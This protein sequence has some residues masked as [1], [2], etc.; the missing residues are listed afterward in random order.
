MPEPE[1]FKTWNTTI[2]NYC[3]SSKHQE[4]FSLFISLRRT[5]SPSRDYEFRPDH[6]TF[7]AL[8]KSCAAI[9]AI[10]L[11]RSF[12][13]FGVKIGHYNELNQVL[14][15]GLMN[16]YAKCG[17]LNDAQK[18]FDDMSQ[19]D[20]PV[21]WNILLSGYAGLRTRDHY[22]DL[23]NL[24]YEMHI[25]KEETKPNEITVAIVLPVCA[26]VRDLRSGKSIHAYVIKSGLVSQTLVGNSLVSMY[27]KCGFAHNDGFLVFSLISCKDVVSWNSMISG[28]IENGFLSDSFKL[29]RQMLKGLTMPNYATIA[30]I[31]PVCAFVEHDRSYFYG[32]EIHCY[33]LRRFELAEEVSVCNSLVSFYSRIG[34]LEEA[35]MVFRRMKSRDLVSWNAIIAGYASNGGGLQKALDLFH[36]LVLTK[37]VKPDSVTLISV[38]PACAQL[39]N[40]KEGQKIHEYVLRDP[41]LRKDTAI[42]NAL[43]SFYSKFNEI[44]AAFRTFMMIPTKDLISWNSVLDAYAE[45]GF[46]IQ[47]VGLL[48]QMF[49]E[50]VRP[51]SITILTVLRVCVAASSAEKIK[52]VHGFS[53]RSGLLLNDLEPTVGNALLDAY[54]KC[55]NM[56]YAIKTFESLLGK[57]NLI[58]NNA[59]ISGY[60]NHGSGENAEMIFNKISQKDLTTWNLMV[61]FHAENNYPDQAINLFHELQR[62]VKPDMLSI[63]SFLPVCACLASLRFVKQCHGYVIRSCFEDVRLNGALL[64][65]Y[66]KCGNIMSAYK[67]FEMSPQKDLVLFTAM[68][69]GFAMHGM[70]DEALQVFYEMLNSGIKPDHII[71]TAALSACS[72]AGLIDQGWKIFESIKRIHGIEPTMENYACLVDLL[73]RGGRLRDAYNFVIGMP[74]EANANI[75]GTLLGACRKQ[76]DLELGRVVAD[77]LFEVEANNI[78]NYVVMSNIYAAN[79]K[80]DGVKEVRRLM[81]DRDLRKPAGCSWIEVEK[82]RHVFVAAD[83]SHPERTFIYSTLCVLDQQI[84]EP[85]C[86]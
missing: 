53:V 63:M 55:E 8:L 29:F 17:D 41:E 42:G 39:Q 38:L 2:K 40:L 60:V 56:E 10:A 11:G 84:K 28:Y 16:I 35:E 24:L 1:D 66:S 57:R 7:A 78:G 73:A 6:Q 59:M 50:G 22:T 15:K 79:A 4:A 37:L 81:K 49:N 51:D 47:L 44:E 30:S 69:G 74:F 82:R 67:L 23:K 52:E 83:T 62:E 36:E 32:K 46:G 86:V 14:C 33:V 85:F 3:T 43:I 31:L 77:R 68:V 27:A 48:H 70:G 54:S 19:R 18:M 76:H 9:S 12:H 5:N 45:N 26:R 25:C 80:W 58:T 71:I 64:D 65:V 75:W 20:D 61:R 72:H 34:R 13:G 21:T